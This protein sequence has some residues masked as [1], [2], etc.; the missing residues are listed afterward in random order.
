M[1]DF[2]QMEA[3]KNESVRCVALGVLGVLTEI[4]LV[5]T[6]SDVEKAEL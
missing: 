5:M 1:F 2:Q 6:P 4:W 3:E